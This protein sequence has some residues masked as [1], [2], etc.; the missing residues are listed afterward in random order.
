MRDYL[1]KVKKRIAINRERVKQIGEM[2]T[3]PKMILL[4]KFH[5]KAMPYTSQ[6]EL[7]KV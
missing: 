4:S 2:G 6:I 5:K 1:K 3:F 7:S